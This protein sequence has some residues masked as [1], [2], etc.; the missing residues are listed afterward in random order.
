MASGVRHTF[1][2]DREYEAEADTAH[3]RIKLE[4][5]HSYDGLRMLNLFGKPCL[6]QLGC[7]RTW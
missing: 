3:Y 2:D 6:Q 1:P 7:G 5:P 4:V